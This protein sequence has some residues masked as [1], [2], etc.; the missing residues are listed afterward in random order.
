MGF[1]SRNVQHVRFRIMALGQDQS[2]LNQRGFSR[3]ISFGVLRDRVFA[4]QITILHVHVDSSSLMANKGAKNGDQIPF[5][6]LGFLLSP[7]FEWS[8]QILDIRTIVY[9]VYLGQKPLTSRILGDLMND[10][11]FSTSSLQSPE[12]KKVQ[13]L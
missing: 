8:N 12:Y 2:P 10:T 5:F 7:L 6:P 13:F 3:I 4:I 11:L 9:I 1:F